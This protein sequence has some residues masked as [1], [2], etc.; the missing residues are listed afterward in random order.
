LTAKKWRDV[1]L[2][3]LMESPNVSAACRR[4]RISRQAAYQERESDPEFAAAWDKAK[5]SGLD[6]LEDKAVQR[7]EKES[8]TLMIFLLKAHRPRVY[9]VPQRQEHSGPGGGAIETNAAVNIYLP[10]NGRDDGDSP[11]A[12]AAGA[13][14]R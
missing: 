10:A 14:P 3:R 6:S 4:A 1:F 2:A 11:A 8:D 9:N 5:E 13:V 12:R 7:A